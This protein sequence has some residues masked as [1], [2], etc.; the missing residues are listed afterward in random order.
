MHDDDE[1]YGR[2][3]G[4]ALDADAA[5]YIPAPERGITDANRATIARLRDSTYDLD[6]ELR[7]IPQKA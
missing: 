3:H 5:H 2:P 4:H 1:G 6:D 7:D